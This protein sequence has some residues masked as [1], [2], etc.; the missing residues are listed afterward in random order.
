MDDETRA[1]LDSQDA[2]IAT[3]NTRILTVEEHSFDHHQA[4]Q[5]VLESL[6]ATAAAVELLLSDKFRRTEEK[7]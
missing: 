3:Q 5:K 1:R 2:I 7:P 6:R 4:I